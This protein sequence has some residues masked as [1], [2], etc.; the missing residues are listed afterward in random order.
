MN[1][2]Y[3]AN[4]VRTMQKI[5]DWDWPDIKAGLEKRG[6]SLAIVARSL[7]ITVSAVA[8]VKFHR[9]VRVEHA[10]AKAL[11]VPPEEIW[12]DRYRQEPRQRRAA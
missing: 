9:S 10:I 11:R 5:S 12:P 2:C 7:D 1:L 3:E 4:I 8:K 6:S